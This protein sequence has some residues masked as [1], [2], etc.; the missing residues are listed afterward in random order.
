MKSHVTVSPVSIVTVGLRAAR[1]VARGGREAGAADVG[2]VDRRRLVG[3]RDAGERDGGAGGEHD[4]GA[5]ARDA[6]TCSSVAEPSA[7]FPLTALRR[8]KLPRE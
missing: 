2:D 8:P 5:R 1:R 6:G 3:A 4:G 7:R